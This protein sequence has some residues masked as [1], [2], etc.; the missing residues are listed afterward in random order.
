M[1]EAQ[2]GR[3][4]PAH[5]IEALRQSNIGKKQS[6]EQIEKRMLK[7]RGRKNQKVKWKN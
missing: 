4:Q 6:K 1:S 7:I 2:K 3:I 5:V